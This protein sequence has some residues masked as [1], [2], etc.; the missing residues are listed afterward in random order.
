MKGTALFGGTQVVNILVNILRGKL[1]AILLGTLGMGISAL[2][3]STLLPL[4][5]LFSLGM[6]LAVVSV[7]AAA[8]ASKAGG[9]HLMRAKVEAY[10]RCLVVLALLGAAVMLIGAPLFSRSAFGDTGHTRAFMCLAAALVFLILEA[11]ETA[12]L[13]A[14]RQMRQVA[15]RSVVNAVGSL[16]I[17]VPLY[18]FFGVRGIVPA[19]VLTAAVVWG[20]SRWQT[21]RLFLCQPS[22]SWSAT[23]Y[24][25][26][27]IM[28]LG[29]FMMLAALFGNLTNYALNALVRSLGGVSDV[30]L[31]QAA[32]SITSQ[33]VGLVFAAMATDY[34]PRLASL[35]DDREGFHTLVHKEY[36]LV[37]LIVAPL[38]AL[39]ILTAPLLIRVLLTTEFL[40]LTGVIRLMG[41]AILCKAA[42]FPLDYVSMA[43]GRKR[44]FFWMEG[45]WCNVKTFAVMALCYY[46]WGLQGLGWGALLSGLIDVVVTTVMTH[47]FFGITTSRL[48]IRFFIPLMLSLGACAAFSLC[49]NAVVAYGGMTLLSAVLSLVCLRLLAR[50]VNLMEWLRGKM[51]FG[52]RR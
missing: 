52:F 51:H 22:Q 7:I 6:P 33:Y 21:R 43:H 42:C 28:A 47:W 19:I 20:Y 23:W 12:V 4:Q 41:L 13:Q 8:D 35:K 44:Y 10:R 40:P 34:F 45:V 26:R 5:Q 50:R 24:L 48:Q 30:G 46:F 32:N 9:R 18:Y 17:G 38:V 36:E 15:V 11:G 29:F 14:R 1:V 49:P 16:L 37:M 25:G 31:Y 39:L 27:G 3:M 2:Y